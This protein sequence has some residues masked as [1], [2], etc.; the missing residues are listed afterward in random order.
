MYVLHCSRW[1]QCMVEVPQNNM[2]EFGQN[3]GFFEECVIVRSTCRLLDNQKSDSTKWI[4]CLT[5][6]YHSKQFV[7]D[8]RKWRHCWFIVAKSL[9][10]VKYN[11]IAVSV[12]LHQYNYTLITIVECYVILYCY[13]LQQKNQGDHSVLKEYIGCPMKN[14]L[15]WLALVIGRLGVQLHINHESL[16]KKRKICPSAKHEDQI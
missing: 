5:S 15:Q 8:T 2:V 3:F 7:V 11:A 12:Q 13:W 10:D 6:F 4:I 14:E 16:P 9:S 1:P